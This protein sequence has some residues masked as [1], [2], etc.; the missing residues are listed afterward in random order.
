[1]LPPRWLSA[2]PGA[3]IFLKLG[4][5][6]KSRSTRILKSRTKVMSV[7][8]WSRTIQRRCS[9]EHFRIPPLA[10]ESRGLGRRVEVKR[11]FEFC[12]FYSSSPAAP[13]G[14]KVWQEKVNYRIGLGS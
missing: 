6:L 2:P 8:G 7:L 5:R 13:H 4:V 10:T 11:L 14:C 12:S 1:M 9:I 3:L